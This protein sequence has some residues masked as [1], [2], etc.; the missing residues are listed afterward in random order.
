MDTPDWIADLRSEILR[1]YNCEAVEGC[2]SDPDLVA[3][4]AA[5]TAD[6]AISDDD[7]IIQANLTGDEA[8]QLR[9]RLAAARKAV[10]ESAGKGLEAAAA[11]LPRMTPQEW[12]T[13]RS[14][15]SRGSDRSAGEPERGGEPATGTS[16]EADGQR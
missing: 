1:K 6:T 5:A 13:V 14:H 16:V 11:A 15:W 2:G 12:S 3:R 8:E 4:L 10:A 7:W 9:E